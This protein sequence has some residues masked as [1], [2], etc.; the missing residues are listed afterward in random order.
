[1]A[2][3]NQFSI[4][5]RFICFLFNHDLI[6]DKIETTIL[7]GWK[8]IKKVDYVKTCKRCWQSFFISIDDNDK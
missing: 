7:S 5:K 3:K 6:I 8:E 4:Y 2:F 1:M